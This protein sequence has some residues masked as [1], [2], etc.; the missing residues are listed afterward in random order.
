[1][2]L[3]GKKNIQR[4]DEELMLLVQK[5][6]P[7][8]FSVL[9]DRY[10]TR[11]VNFFYLRLGYDEP[12]AQDFLH[13]LFV[14]ILQNPL[15]FAPG[16]NFRSWLYTLAMNM[17]KNE[18]RRQQVREEYRVFVRNSSDG[19][20][21]ENSISIDMKLFGRELLIKLDLLPAAQRDV[22]LLRFRE[23]LTIGEISE[24]LGIPEGTVKSRLFHVLRILALH[25]K[26]FDPVQSG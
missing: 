2:P 16:N 25:L 22:F 12:K 9:Y 10:A 4:N 11:M 20:A 24:V 8:A 7:E 14:K 3:S 17:C 13:D 21:E 5:N 6:D 15:S 23:E 1:M 18:Y 26:K 19:I